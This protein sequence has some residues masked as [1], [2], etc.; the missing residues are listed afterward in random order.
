[1]SARQSRDPRSRRCYLR[2]SP[3]DPGEQLN[4]EIQDQADLN[5]SVLFE[6]ALCMFNREQRGSLIRSRWELRTLTGEEGEQKRVSSRF[7]SG[8]AIGS[9]EKRFIQDDS[10]GFDSCNPILVTETRTC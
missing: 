4:P 2:S 5:L 6:S 8:Q 7:C 1:M 9:A 10:G 3:G